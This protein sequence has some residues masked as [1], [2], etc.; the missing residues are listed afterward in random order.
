MFGTKSEKEDQEP[1]LSG[2]AD[3]PRNQQSTNQ[4]WTTLPNLKFYISDLKSDC[5]ISL[6]LK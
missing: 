5:R 3:K 1:N 2:G 4:Q 6:I